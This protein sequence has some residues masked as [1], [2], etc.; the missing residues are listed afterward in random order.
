M[1]DRLASVKDSAECLVLRYCGYLE[2]SFQ[3]CSS[4]NKAEGEEGARETKNNCV[5]VHFFP[6]CS[7]AK[8]NT[9]KLSKASLLKFIVRL[10]DLDE[11]VSNHCFLQFL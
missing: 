11:Y 9:M 4:E 2:V 7:I 3:C 5:S 10:L 6:V 1:E 8:D